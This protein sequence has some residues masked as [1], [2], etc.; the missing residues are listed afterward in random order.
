MS[1]TVS[2]TGVIVQSARAGLPLQKP[3]QQK[4]G[5]GDDSYAI[6]ATER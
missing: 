5:E 1:E 2:P 6:P 4:K 3:A